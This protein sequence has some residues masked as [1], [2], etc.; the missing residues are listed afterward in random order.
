MT[1]LLGFLLVAADRVTGANEQAPPGPGTA[2][3]IIVGV[4]ALLVIVALGVYFAFRRD[5]I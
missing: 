2:I 4:L 3:P 1:A 5:R